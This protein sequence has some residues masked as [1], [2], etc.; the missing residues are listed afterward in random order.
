MSGPI[1]T[2]KVHKATKIPR[3]AIKKVTRFY[4]GPSQCRPYTYYN[5]KDIWRGGYPPCLGIRY[6]AIL[7]IFHTYLCTTNSKHIWCVHQLP[8][9]PLSC[10]QAF[11]QEGTH[12]IFLMQNVTLTFSLNSDT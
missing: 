9:W 8:H 12:C 3:S 10:E 4:K 1:I 2:T 11:F 6:I 5:L 7:D